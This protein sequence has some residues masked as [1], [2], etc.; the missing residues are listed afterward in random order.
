MPGEGAEE[1]SFSRWIQSVI[2]RWVPAQRKAIEE[3][4]ELAK[5]TSQNVAIRHSSLSQ[6]DQRKLSQ[7]KIYRATVINGMKELDK[8]DEARH[9]TH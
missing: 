3:A 4:R 6:R 1:V 2:M 5:R 9:E 8:G 7:D